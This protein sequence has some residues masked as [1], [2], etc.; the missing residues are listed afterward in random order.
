[1]SSYQ[2]LCDRGRATRNRLPEPPEMVLDNIAGP[3]EHLT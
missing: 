1:M 3:R 2:L